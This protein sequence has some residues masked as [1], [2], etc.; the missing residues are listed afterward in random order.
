MGI[1]DWVCYDQLHQNLIFGLYF[2][3][4]LKMSL[5]RQKKDK[6]DKLDD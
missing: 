5:P 4:N 6:L 2:S 3:Q 1:I